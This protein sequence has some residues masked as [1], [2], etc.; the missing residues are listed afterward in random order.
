[1]TVVTRA[2]IIAVFA[3]VVSVSS[4]GFSIFVGLRDRSRLVATSRFS[5]T[6]E[7]GPARLH[8]SVVNAGRRPIV[9]RMLVAVCDDDDWF[10]DFLGDHKVGLRLGEHERHDITLE[11]S[12]LLGGRESDLIATDFQI[13]DSLGRR[14]SV[15]DAKKH[16]GLLL[17]S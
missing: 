7:Y 2:E 3:L 5:A 1:M 6:S 12:D 11:K 8:I 4:L 15:R 10:G 13:E 14:H 17:A 16:V 9:V